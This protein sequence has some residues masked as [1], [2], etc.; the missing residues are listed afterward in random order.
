MTAPA[1]VAP[2]AEDAEAMLGLIGSMDLLISMRLHTIIF[3]ARERVPVVGCVYDPKVEA[4]LKQL[5]MPSCGTPE[6]LDVERAVRVA[7]ELLARRTEAKEELD[8]RISA[9]EQEAGKIGTWLLEELG[10]RS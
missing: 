6:A 10:I 2:A 9:M 8:A 1:Y 4:F 5:D 7:E 3:A